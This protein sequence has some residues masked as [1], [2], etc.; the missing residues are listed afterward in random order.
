MGYGV[1]PLQLAGEESCPL[2]VALEDELLEQVLRYLRQLL[3]Q[4]VLELLSTGRSGKVDLLVGD[5]P[6]AQP[7]LD[8]A[9]V[10]LDRV[11]R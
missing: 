6:V 9:E 1:G 8:D 5:H 3:G 10:V 11:E 2:L 7:L 4:S